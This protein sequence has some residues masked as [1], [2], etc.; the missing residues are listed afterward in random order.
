MFCFP[1]GNVEDTPD[2][3][4]ALNEN[5]VLLRNLEKEQFNRLSTKPTNDEPNLKPPTA[6]EQAIAEKLEQSLL[7]LSGAVTPADICDQAGL[8]KAMGVSTTF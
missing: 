4:T 1:G 5:S 7:T 2:V 3:K 8:R 6:K